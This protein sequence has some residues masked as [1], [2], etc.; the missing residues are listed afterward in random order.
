VKTFVALGI[1]ILGI[2]ILLNSCI[3]ARDNSG[4]SMHAASTRPWM[5][6]SL[7]PEKRAQL[8]VGH[9]TLEEKILEIH[10]LDKPGHP[11]EVAGVERL[12][13]PVFK[14]TNGPCGAGPGDARPTQPATALPCALALSASWDPDL[15][16]KFGELAGREVKDRG[17]HLIEG[18]GVNITRV[19]QCGRNFEYFGEDPYLS[20][21]LGVAEIQALQYERVIAEVKHYACNNQETARKS[22]NEIVDERT[23]REIYLPAFEACIKEGDSGAVMAAYPSVNGAFCSQNPHLLADILRGEWGFKGFVQSDYT[24]TRSAVQ[25]AHAGLDLSMKA[26]HYATEMQQAVESGEVSESTLDTM[27]ARR[28]AQMFRFGM[29]DEQRTPKPI[30]A[31]QDGAVSREI[32][33]QCCVLL[34]NQNDL[35]PLRADQLRTIAVIGPYAKYA[36][37]GGGGSSAV[38]P[39]YTVSPVDGIQNRVGN[40]VHVV[41]N[42]GANMSAATDAAKSAD[43]VLLMVGNKDSEGRDRKNLSLAESQDD[44]ISAVA[45]VNPRT[46]LILK[47]GGP[48]LMPWIDH[49]PAILEAWYPGEEDGNVV[50]SILF[51]DVNPSGKL[52]MTFPRA[53][54]ET[55]AHTPEQWPGVDGNATYSEKLN[56]GYRWYDAQNVE[57]LF[58]FGFG[59]SYTKFAMSNPRITGPSKDHPAHIEVD[60]KNTGDCPGAE[61]VQVYVA[62]P[63]VAGEPPKQLKGFAKVQLNPGETRSVRIDLDPRAF[64]VWDTKSNR[65]TTVPGEH[66]ILV[67]DSS[68][69][70]PLKATVAVGS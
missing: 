61:T 63:S 16:R 40:K 4:S 67:G 34:K 70:L 54:T 2:C 33:Q 9:M 8:L 26:D 23:L 27:L 42:D 37:T 7:Q 17:E 15:A 44:L 6:T 69:E 56:V 65:W 57:P 48:V 49:I 55:P 68:R 39:L 25:G 10:M 38:A 5:N 31:K 52:P 30:P 64:S 35:L 66:Q 29:F 60:V 46:I 47:T 22:I 19:P 41:F 43:I 3:G 24:G 20:A 14:I 51:G 28:F 59:L 32:A 11:R 21:R 50:A 58:P 1:C 18:P 45:Q 62:A 36:H 53:E 13:I 12:G